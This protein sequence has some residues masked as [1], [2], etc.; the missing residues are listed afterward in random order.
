MARAPGDLKV[1]GSVKAN[2]PTSQLHEIIP[3]RSRENHPQIP[4]VV[5]DLLVVQVPLAD[6]AKQTVKLI[7]GEHRGRRIIDRLGERPDRYIDDDAEREG[8][9]LLDGALTSEG[10]RA[11]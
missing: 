4:G 6:S 7:D 5:H 8:R 10:N 9:V 3:I 11:S 2:F 1:R